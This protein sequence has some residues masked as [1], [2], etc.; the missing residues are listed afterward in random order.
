MIYS[1]KVIGIFNNITTCIFRNILASALVNFWRSFLQVCTES[2]H[3]HNEPLFPLEN[4][5][6]Y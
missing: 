6:A 1:A 5:I 2:Q 4:L 3:I